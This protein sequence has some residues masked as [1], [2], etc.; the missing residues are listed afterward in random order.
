MISYRVNNGTFTGVLRYWAKAID[1]KA[2]ARMLLIILAD[3]VTR[4]AALLLNLTRQPFLI[5]PAV[6]STRTTVAQNRKKA[7]Y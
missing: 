1:G 5:L 2:L 7:R 3:S 4:Q 6:C